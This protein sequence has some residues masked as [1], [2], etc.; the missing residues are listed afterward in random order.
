VNLVVA[1]KDVGSIAQI[2][3]DAE[4]HHRRMYYSFWAIQREGMA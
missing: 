2:Y 3:R 4:A 1:N